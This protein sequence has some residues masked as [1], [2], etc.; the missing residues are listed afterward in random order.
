MTKKTNKAKVLV[1]LTFEEM[2][3]RFFGLWYDDA[4]VLAKLL[5]LDEPEEGESYEDWIE[6]KVSQFQILKTAYETK[7]YSTLATIDTDTISLITKAVTDY[8]EVKKSLSSQI[9]DFIGK[10]LGGSKQDTTEEAPKEHI[11]K[12]IIK[13]VD[14][15]KREVTFI[16]YEPDTLDAH[17][18]WCDKETLAKACNDFNEN[19][20]KGKVV[21]NL[22]HTKDANG[23]YS[24]TDSFEIL[25]TFI[26]DYDCVIGG[27]DIKE[28]TWLAKIKIKN[29]VLWEN[30][31]AGKVKGLSIG[32]V[33]VV[34]E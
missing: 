21:P 15:L 7:D 22:F 13:S 16:V 4:E 11:A 5:G 27:Q 29:D 31:V 25:K 8:S 20:S 14:E 32:C 9:L 28:G 6:E 24:K 34:G 3:V 17:G 23:N 30:F 2:L 18:E 19:L 12:T 26:V 33:A 10:R 1:T